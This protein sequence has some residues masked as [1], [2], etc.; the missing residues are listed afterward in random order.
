[1]NNQ[2]ISRN[3][4]FRCVM[5]LYNS[6]A[7]KLTTA[8][9]RREAMIACVDEVQKKT[10]P[11]HKK[12]NNL[13]PIYVAAMMIQSEHILNISFSDYPDIYNS[14][15]GIYTESGEEEGIYY[16]NAESVMQAIRCYAPN[17]STQFAKEVSTILSDMSEVKTVNRNPNLIPVGNG[18]FDYEHKVLLPFTPDVVFTAKAHTRF[19]PLAQNPVIQ[20]P[21]GTLWD[22]HS[23]LYKLFDGD[24][25]KV[26]LIFQCLGA[27]LRP[28]QRWGKAL[29]LYSHSKASGKSSVLALARALC[30][31]DACANLPL[32]RL[33]SRFSLAP[34]LDKPSVVIVG[35]DNSQIQYYANMRI[36]KTLCS[37]DVIQVDRPYR[38]PV[39]FRPTE[40]MVQALSDYPVVEQTAH[41]MIR[42]FIFL[43]LPHDFHAEGTLNPLIKNDYLCREDVLEYL[44]KYLLVD[45]PNYYEINTPDYQSLLTG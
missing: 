33:E 11:N 24:T 9:Q 41:S 45:M 35:D 18:I 37:N 31:M 1:M 14:V 27:A 7:E 21:D 17:C 13:S 8:A 29:I 2:I 44:M 25:E 39:T 12:S 38:K 30:G 34:L 36:I 10:N 40:F 32:H 22:I 16:T 28:H 15:L 4:F 3:H 26:D 42:R 20:Q 43:E 19:N 23:W 6:K 5:S